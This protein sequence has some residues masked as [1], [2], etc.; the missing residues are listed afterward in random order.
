VE[1]DTALVLVGDEDADFVREG[2]GEGVAARRLEGLGVIEW[3][4]YNV[5]TVV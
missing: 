4:L 3:P 2:I 5:L 1:G